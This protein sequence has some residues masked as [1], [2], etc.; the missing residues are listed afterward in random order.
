MSLLWFQHN[1]L[2]TD[3]MAQRQVVKAFDA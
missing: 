1:P 3:R 2:P